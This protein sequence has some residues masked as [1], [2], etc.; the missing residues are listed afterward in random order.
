MPRE[1]LAEATFYRLA[2]G[3][4]ESDANGPRIGGVALLR[5]THA[6]AR[7]PRW[8][9][10]PLAEIESDLGRAYG[11]PIG[12]AGKLGGLGVV[13]DA[14]AKGELARAQ[15]ATLLLRLPDPLRSGADPADRAE[16]E[17]RLRASGLLKDWNPDEHSRAGIPPTSSPPRRSRRWSRRGPAAAEL[18]SRWSSARRRQVGVSAPTSRSA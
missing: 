18:L 7:A 13:A 10:P 2:A 1:T 8:R 11:R 14:L 6:E 17:K 5:A 16:L 3:A 9:L 4:V 15:I 12:A